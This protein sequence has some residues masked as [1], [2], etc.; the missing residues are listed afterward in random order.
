MDATDA[1]VMDR[2]MALDRLCGDAEL[3]DELIGLMIEQS[4]GL[5]RDIEAALLRGDVAAVCIA[6]HTIRGSAANLEAVPLRDAAGVLE[7]LARE[8]DLRDGAAAG[9]ALAAELERLAAEVGA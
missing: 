9:A 3:L 6:A 2:A 4:R 7:N 5:V 8:G 1:P